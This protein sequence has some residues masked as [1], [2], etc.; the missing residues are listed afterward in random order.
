M[1]LGDFTDLEIKVKER[2]R[3]RRG[4]EKKR[5]GGREREKGGERGREMKEGRERARKRED[6]RVGLI[7]I[8]DIILYD[9]FKCIYLFILSY[10]PYFLILLLPLNR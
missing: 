5:E 8:V 2:E 9:L 3:K 1:V 6:I 10:L 4:K 7:C